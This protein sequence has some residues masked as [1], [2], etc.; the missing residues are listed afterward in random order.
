MEK[1]QIRLKQNTECAR[2][3]RKDEKK[4]KMQIRLEEREKQMKRKARKKWEV[5]DIAV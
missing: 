3:R 1:R 5:K 2:N 4:E